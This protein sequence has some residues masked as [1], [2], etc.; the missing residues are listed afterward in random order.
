M[1]VLLAVDPEAVELDP[2]VAD[3]SDAVVEADEALA[4][5]ASSTLPLPPSSA[6]CPLQFVMNGLLSLTISSAYPEP[7]CSDDDGVHEN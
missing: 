6:N 5:E 3:A 4:G 2:A 7:D 1:V